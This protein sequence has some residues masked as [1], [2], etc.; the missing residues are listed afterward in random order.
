MSS[1]SFG[2]LLEALPTEGGGSGVTETAST[3]AA[4]DLFPDI[5]QQGAAGPSSSTEGSMLGEG[6]CSAFEGLGSPQ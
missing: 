3:I 5:R 4:A 1:S 2:N 6:V